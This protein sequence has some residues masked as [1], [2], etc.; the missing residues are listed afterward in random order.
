MNVL[1]DKGHRLGKKRWSGEKE[2][3]IHGESFLSRFNKH[4]KKK[5]LWVELR[6]TVQSQG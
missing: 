2:M 3:G 4:Q 5:V 1:V 6:V